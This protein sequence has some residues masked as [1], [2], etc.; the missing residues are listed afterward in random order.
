MSECV[1]AKE[2]KN[3]YLLGLEGWLC[4]K[5]AHWAI[6]ARSGETEALLWPQGRWGWYRHMYTSVLAV[7]REVWDQ[8]GGR[9][10][11]RNIGGCGQYDFGMLQVVPQA[12]TAGW[13]H[14]FHCGFTGFRTEEAK[15][16]WKKSTLKSKG[17]CFS[18]L[19]SWSKERVGQRG[20][21]HREIL[22]LG[23]IQCSHSHQ[24]LCGCWCH[25]STEF[26]WTVGIVSLTY[27]FQYIMTLILL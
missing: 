20:G 15:K 23:T 24:Q 22:Y 3:A 14:C 4:L 2:S 11:Q 21:Y 10:K 16:S 5:A 27:R 17:S 25:Y 1:G 26:N 12:E 13:L 9:P 7:N 19:F 6:R 18:F 8:T